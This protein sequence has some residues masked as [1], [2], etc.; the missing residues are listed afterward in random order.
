M[1]DSA[2]SPADEKDRL[3]ALRSYKIMNTPPEEAFD[4]IVRLA[5]KICN[6][7]M[8]AITLIDEH[9]AWFKAKVGLEISQ[10]DRHP[11]ICN[12]ALRDEI[13]IVNDTLGDP[14]FRNLPAVLDA[15][16]VRFYAGVPIVTADRFV[17]GTLC[18]MDRVP[19]E[20]TPAQLEILELLGRQ[21]VTQLELRR[22][23]RERDE[24][25]ASLETGNRELKAFSGAVSHDLRGPIHRIHALAQI[26]RE[27]YAARLDDE[28][29]Q[30]LQRII[31]NCL[32]MERLLESL[33]RLSRAMESLLRLEPIDLTAMATQIAAALR[34]EDPDRRAE[35]IIAP[36]LKAF[37]DR[38]LVQIVLETLIGNAWK[39]TR[40][41]SATRIEFGLRTENGHKIF[42]VRDNGVGFDPSAISRLF[43]PFERFGDPKTFQGI[44]LGLY[45]ARR[46]IERHGGRIW[47]EGRPDQG[48][49]FYF[50]LPEH[51]PP[52]PTPA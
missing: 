50:T 49:T 3:E 24:A 34:T 29:Q 6:T 17:L 48:A 1:A 9:R 4:S 7:P 30:H 21:T 36:E 43:Q 20:L 39:F 38:P 46:I 25:I 16:K 41:R 33:L 52:K 8:A 2:H 14:R 47:A 5:A 10:V 44:G 22:A 11:S 51:E 12:V 23:L 40:P 19:R 35:F 27:D 15:P 42:F 13:L 37:G 26:L 18:I 28:G 31:D 45:T 32:V